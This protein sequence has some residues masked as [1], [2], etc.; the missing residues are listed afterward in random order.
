MKPEVASN[1]NRIDRHVGCRLSLA[2][3]LKIVQV[4]QL[5]LEI[6]AP[7][8]H[9]HEFR[10]GTRRIGADMLFRLSQT[11]DLPMGFFFDFD[12][13]DPIPSEAVALYH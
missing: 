11:L 3:Q 2:M 5:A 13:N 8:Q 4:V 9:V 1:P 12:I 7:P 10:D 6:G